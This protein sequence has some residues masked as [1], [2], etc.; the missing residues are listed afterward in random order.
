MTQWK[1]L[2]AA[3]IVS[4]SIAAPSAASVISFASHGGTADGQSCYDNS[5]MATFT[6]FDANFLPTFS[7][8]ANALVVGNCTQITPHAAWKP[9]AQAN[10]FVDDNTPSLLDDNPVWISHDTD[11]TLDGFGT[12]TGIT[13]TLETVVGNTDKAKPNLIVTQEFSLTSSGF[14][15]LR[16]WADDTV[17]VYIDGELLAGAEEANFSQQTCAMGPPGCQVGESSFGETFLSAGDHVFSWV[18]WQVG[19]G[20]TAS[21]NPFGLLYVGQVET[22]VPEPA[23]FA[24]LGLGLVG[25]GAARRGRRAA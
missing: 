14:A 9:G 21:S 3:A 22:T 17:E 8:G 6:G 10:V 15:S 24:L 5:G 1:F 18:L 11:G 12:G 20:N 13:G 4:A 2:A 19:T 7:G 23:A 25:I 16:Q